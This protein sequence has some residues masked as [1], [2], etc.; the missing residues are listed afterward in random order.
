[1]ANNE[2]H[3]VMGLANYWF[4]QLYEEDD[5]LRTLYL[6][7]GGLTVNAVAC[8]YWRAALRADYE[9]V[10]DSAVDTATDHIA[11]VGEAVVLANVNGVATPVSLIS[12]CYLWTVNESGVVRERHTRA[13]RCLSTIALR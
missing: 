10:A 7:G 3:T 1:M 8:T 13:A 6:N 9:R 11:V 2:V 12:Q 4:L 5:A